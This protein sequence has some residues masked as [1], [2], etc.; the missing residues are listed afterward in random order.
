MVEMYNVTISNLLAAELG[1]FEEEEHSPAFIS[2][3]RF[4]PNQSE[5][6]E[7]EIYNKYKSLRLASYHCLQICVVQ[8]ELISL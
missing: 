3:F 8:I 7:V 5:E 6:M 2:E 4:M 1:D